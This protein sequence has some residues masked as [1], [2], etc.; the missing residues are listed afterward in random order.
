MSCRFFRM[1]KVVE[2]SADTVHFRRGGMVINRLSCNIRI[3]KKVPG[4][5][6]QPEFI[7]RSVI[8]ADIGAD[9]AG[10]N[11]IDCDAT[12]FKH[13][14]QFPDGEKLCGL[15]G[16]VASKPRIKTFFPVEIVETKA[17]KTMTFRID[18]YNSSRSMLSKSR[19]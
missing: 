14:I 2:F 10:M 6:V 11:R 13:I 4:D 12:A 19:D 5:I 16:T 7:E 9:F 15:R 18:L 8:A 17:A 3:F 1:S